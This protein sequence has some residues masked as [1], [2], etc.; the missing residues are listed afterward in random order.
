MALPYWDST[1][2]FRMV[3]PSKSIYWTEIFVGN[4]TGVVY[5]GPFADW[6]TPANNTLLRRGIP[7]PGSSLL[8]PELLREVFKQKYHYQILFPTNVSL[9]SNFET[10]HDGVHRWIGGRDGHMG[11]L[12]TSPQE[13]A[14]WNFH[15]HIDYL[16]EQFR[17]QQR[18]RGIDSSRD[19]PLM[20]IPV[21][22][23]FRKMD[24]LWPPLR[25]IDGYS[26]VFTQ[27]I[28]RYEAA[29]TC[30]NKC[31]GA[32][33]EYLY[34]NR[35]INQCVSRS[36]STF[37]R[38]TGIGRSRQPGSATGLIQ[39]RVASLQ[40]ERNVSLSSLADRPN[41]EPKFRKAIVDP[42]TT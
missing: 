34:C 18:R 9:H 31:G 5:T 38:L 39:D 16:W 32:K 17:E 1:L 8:N 7:G 25:N 3:D 24:N 6:I 12:S 33:T 19:Y 15:C 28:Y 26:N 4:P 36:R 22:Q 37:E 35:R 20:D 29:P 41:T 10:H 21:H 40:P 30:R 23:P 2:D 27:Y 11:G 13:P 14:F 42:R